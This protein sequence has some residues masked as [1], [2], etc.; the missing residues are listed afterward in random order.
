MHIPISYIRPTNNVYIF[1]KIAL[2]LLNTNVPTF[3]DLECNDQRLMKI[4]LLRNNKKSMFMIYSNS[5]ENYFTTLLN[6]AKKIC[7]KV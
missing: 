6:D 4:Y 1:L 2:I 3:I 5:Q 7:T